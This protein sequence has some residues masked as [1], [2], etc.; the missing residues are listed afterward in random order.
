MDSFIMVRIGV[1]EF[2]SEKKSG[3]KIRSNLRTQIIWNLHLVSVVS[4]DQ[5]YL[6]DVHLVVWYTLVKMKS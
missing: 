4:I 1:E 2:S 6:W 5:S 3:L